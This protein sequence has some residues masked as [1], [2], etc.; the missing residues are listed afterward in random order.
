MYSLIFLTKE[1]DLNKVLKKQRAV[2]GSIKILYTS[3]WDPTSQGVVQKLRDKYSTLGKG[4]DLYI[5]DSFKMP[6]AF[7][8]FKTTKLPQLITLRNNSILSDDYLPRVLHL[9]NIG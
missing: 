6:H 1:N 3:L 8:I 2:G 5:V 4:E 7:V 9:L